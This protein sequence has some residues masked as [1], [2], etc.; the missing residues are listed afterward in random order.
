[1]DVDKTI[2]VVAEM[3]ILAM[4]MF[5][6]AFFCLKT[7]FIPDLTEGAPSKIYEVE[8]KIPEGK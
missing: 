8:K 7:L 6:A 2:E 4:V 3:T 5:L 1:M